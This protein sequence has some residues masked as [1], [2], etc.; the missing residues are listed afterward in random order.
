MKVKIYNELYKI[1]PNNIN[2]SFHSINSITYNKIFAINNPKFYKESLNNIK[3]MIQLALNVGIAVTV[4]KYNID[5]SE[6]LIHFFTAL[7]IPREKIT[8]NMLLKGSRDT[9][10]LRPSYV[11]NIS[12]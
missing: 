9:A 6:E 12:Q 10:N 3:E 1:N 2:V 11:L 8:F 7:G 4:T 5:E